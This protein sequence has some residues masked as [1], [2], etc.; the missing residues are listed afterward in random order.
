MSLDG[1]EGLRKNIGAKRH[2]KQ[3][4]LVGCTLTKS[5]ISSKKGGIQSLF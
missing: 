1:G 2:E 5:G 3:T 4:E